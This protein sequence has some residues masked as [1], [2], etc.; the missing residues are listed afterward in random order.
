MD[1]QLA[2]AA[3]AKVSGDNQIGTAGRVLRYPLVVVITNADG[4]PI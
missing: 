2:Q 1:R 3:I 4:V